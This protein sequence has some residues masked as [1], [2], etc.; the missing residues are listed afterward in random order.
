MCGGGSDVEAPT[1]SAEERAN[2]AKQ[3]ELLE[4]AEAREKQIDPILMAEYGYTYDPNGTLR[5]MTDEE[6]YNSLGE[7][8]KQNYDIQKL[9]NQRALDAYNGKLEI[10]PTLTRAY[11]EASQQLAETMSRNL[12]VGWES[13]TPGIKALSDLAKRKAES[14]Y[15]VAHGEM[16]NSTAVANQEQS[17][18]MQKIQQ[19]MEGMSARANAPLNIAQGYQ[20]PLSWYSQL[21]NQQLQAGALNAQLNAAN[22]NSLYSGISGIAGMGM[23]GYM[24]SM[25]RR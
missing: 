7:T 15:A 14:E 12:G 22:R 20:M 4:R 6:Y 2:I 13:S 25:G 3:T 21:R 16:T 9:A 10:D 24:S 19:A 5:K 8:E 23:G 17:A 11:D 18:Q 1:P